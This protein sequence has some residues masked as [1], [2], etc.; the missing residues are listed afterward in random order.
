VG[1]AITLLA[2]LSLA[3]R[4]GPPAATENPTLP[5]ATGNPSAVPAST[6]VPR[7]LF[8]RSVV[9]DAV[10]GGGVVTTDA[11]DGF[12]IAAADRPR[13]SHAVAGVAVGKPIFDG[14][15]R[16][17]YWRVAGMTRAFEITGG[18]E[19]VVWDIQSDRD[20]VLLT[21]R[22]ERPNGTGLWSA[23][24]KSLVMPTRSAP[25]T[26]E[27]QAR[28]LVIDADSGA[29]RV[30][31]ANAGEAAV[32]PVF[33]DAQIVA[34]VRGRSFI[35]FDA[36]SGAVRTQSTMRV[37]STPM[38]ESTELA[39]SRDGT[40]LELLRR[41]ESEAGP[42]WIWNVRDPGKDVAKVDERGISDPIFWPQRTE[43]VFSGAT[44]LMTLDYRSGKARR[45]RSP[46]DA[47]RVL[48]IEAGGRFAMLQT[49]S[50]SQMFERTGDELKVR[51]DL[52][53][54]VGPTLRPLGMFLP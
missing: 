48:A 29:T 21:L 26:A 40:I 30:L 23:D 16:V 38:G 2:A 5:A 28:L 54:T 12:E 7:I 6:V 45:L 22:D 20:R 1:T 14:L 44:G 9:L 18:Y 33:A 37:P 49:E 25:A 39:S 4:A 47:H 27:A 13:Q 46:P 24:L 19:L 36:A 31:S 52:Q 17:A 11:Y 15:G 3:L 51:P 10:P 42:L 43:V 8:A 41:F 35:V 53:V 34:G 32:A 50:G